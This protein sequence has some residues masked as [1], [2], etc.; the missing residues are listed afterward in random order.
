MRVKHVPAP[1]ASN[2][3][4]RVAETQAAVP[5]V[6]GTEADCCARLQRR[7]GFDSRDVSRTW[8]T[9]LRGVGYVEET[10]DGFR[11][12]RTE[13]TVG[14]TRR[15]VVT[16]VVGAGR[17]ADALHEPQTTDNAFEAVSDAVPRWERTRTD[18]WEAVWRQRTERLLGW[19]DVL[20]LARGDK[21][22]RGTEAL[23][24]CLN[25]A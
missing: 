19:F 4:E 12:V 16:G 7:V 5:L 15:G 2:P 9:F 17:L 1:P 14:R 6:P 25:D 10:S 3:V 21:L 18:D 22:Y 13:P 20:G 8:L 23:E 24:R 11:R